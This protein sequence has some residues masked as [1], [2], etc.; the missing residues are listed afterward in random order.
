M[1]KPVKPHFSSS[2]PLLNNPCCCSAWKTPPVPKQE[3]ACPG[4]HILGMAVSRAEFLVSPAC[5][6]RVSPPGW[7]HTL[8]SKCAPGGGFRPGRGGEGRQHTRAQ[9]PLP[10]TEWGMKNRDQGESGSG[11]QQTPHKGCDSV[12]ERLSLKSCVCRI[13]SLRKAKKPLVS[14]FVFSSSRREM[15]T[16]SKR[17]K[18]KHLK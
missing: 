11:G 1:H 12:R 6:P 13:C 7:E 4:K 9:Q 14:G 10:Q 16:Q 15:Q 2:S 8:C 17:G 3:Q 5:H 18:K